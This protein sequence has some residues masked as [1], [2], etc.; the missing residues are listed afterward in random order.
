MST[1]LI[2]EGAEL[3]GKSFLMSQVYPILERKGTRSRNFLDGCAWIN[4]DIGVL[5]GE[6]GEAMV[7]KYVEIAGILK[8]RSVMFEKLHLTDT[9][10]KIQTGREIPDY[11]EV[12]RRLAQMHYKIVLTVFDESE[13]LLEKRLKERLELYPHYKKIAKKPAFYINQQ[14]IYRERVRKTTLPHLE[15]NLRKFSEKEIQPLR[16][17]IF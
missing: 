15:I 16:D 17:W 2:F 12:E 3:S 9:V 8:K 11:S 7:T 6:Y 14:K 1:H 4:S 13:S 10:Y 5:G